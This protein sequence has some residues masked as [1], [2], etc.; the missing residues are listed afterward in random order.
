MELRQ[1]LQ[2]IRNW[3]SPTVRAS[4][5]SLF[6]DV[7]ITVRIVLSGSDILRRPFK[8]TNLDIG[9]LIVGCLRCTTLCA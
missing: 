6:V 1:L 2:L 5:E 8:A 7:V 3:K 4:P 9:F